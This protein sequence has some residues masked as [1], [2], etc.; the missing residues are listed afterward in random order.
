MRTL[1]R[2]FIEERI[3]KKIETMKTAEGVIKAVLTGFEPFRAE[4]IRDVT[5][6]DVDR[7]LK[8]P[9]RRISLY[10]INKNRAEVEEIK[11]RIRE[12]NKLL[13]N[14][15]AYAISVLDGI[16]SRLDPVETARKTRIDRFSKVDV[17][18]AVTRD[19]PL[20]Y[21]AETGYLGTAVASGAEILKVTPY[22]RVLV[23]RKSGV[24]TVMDVPEKLFVDA[25]LWYCGFS[26]K[27]ILSK[28]LFTVIYRDPK[29]GFPCIKRCRVEGYILNRDYLIAPEGAEILYV[30]TKDKF[31]FTLNYVPIPRLKTLKQS[32]KAQDYAEKG[33]K[34]QGVRL[35]NREVKSVEAED[36]K[37]GG[38][39]K[40][41]VTKEPDLFDAAETPPETAQKRSTTVAEK[42]AVKPAAKGLKA[43]A[44]QAA[45]KATAKPSAKPSPKPAEGKKKAAP[46]AA[47]TKKK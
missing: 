47:P 41:G 23:M 9:I 40:S 5:E 17:K 27:E 31:L 15:T 1:E 42:A 26:E 7:L 11:A 45:Q 29:S 19:T 28:V 46:K 22:D 3:Y 18:E 6:D 39:A 20:K 35:A 24:Y 36:G 34:A 4:L 21:D 14:L 10:D 43:A 12:I 33:L 30:G 16:L 37:K 32:F 25:G 38:V 8:I 13:K 44:T 2:I